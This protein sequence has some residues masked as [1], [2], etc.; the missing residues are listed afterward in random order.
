MLIYLYNN[1]NHLLYQGVIAQTARQVA[2]DQK[3]R[4]SNPTICTEITIHYLWGIYRQ[5]PIFSL[6]TKNTF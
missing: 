4:G 5:S 6:V 2:T 1:Y 3:V